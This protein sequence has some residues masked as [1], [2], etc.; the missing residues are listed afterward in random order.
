MTT[1]NYHTST[2]IVQLS[3]NVLV[4]LETSLSQSA[5]PMFA[6]VQLGN[7]GNRRTYDKI[8]NFFHVK[9]NCAIFGTKLY[10]SLT[11]HL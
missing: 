3:N 10:R 5:T 8:N 6:A 2:D 9:L 7:I 4:D 11:D 1:P